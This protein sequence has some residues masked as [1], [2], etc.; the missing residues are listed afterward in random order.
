MKKNWLLCLA[1]LVLLSMACSLSIQNPQTIEGS[2]VVTSETRS[3]SGFN[4]IEL[5]GSADVIVSLGDA[6][7]VVVEAEDNLLPLITTEVRGS[8]LVINFKPNTRVNPTKLI[9]VTIKMRSFEGARISGSGNVTVTGL[10]AGQVKFD[11][12]GSGNITA[13]GT[14]ETVNVTLEGSGNVQCGDLQA[15]SAWVSLDGSGN[16]TVF[17]NENLDAK[18][19][20]SGTVF[21]AG[22]PAEVNTSV[23]GS[24]SILP[25][26]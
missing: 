3:V 22:D 6:E 23:P 14:V 16:V 25:A 24:G 8:K 18:I 19:K 13:D 5:A 12:P 15:R 4:E 21:Y 20:G 2:G 26:P 17:A 11:L 10:S 9:R 7:S 1:V